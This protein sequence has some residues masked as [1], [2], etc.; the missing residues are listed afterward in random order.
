MRSSL[1]AILVALP[2]TFWGLAKVAI[3]TTNV[4]TKHEL[5]TYEKVPYEALNRHFCKTAVPVAQHH[6]V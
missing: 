5:Q 1:Y 2:T 4:D 6:I 3:L